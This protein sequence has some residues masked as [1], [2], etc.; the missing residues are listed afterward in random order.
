MHLD[1][2]PH[3]RSIVKGTAG[4]SHRFSERSRCTFRREKEGVDRREIRS[5]DFADIPCV[6]S[7]TVRI[8]AAHTEVRD[9]S[10]EQ[11]NAGGNNRDPHVL[12]DIAQT[13]QRTTPD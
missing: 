3:S 13:A 6:I 4:T 1:D 9:G 5:A 11:W 10:I 12:L 2:D 8:D 7:I